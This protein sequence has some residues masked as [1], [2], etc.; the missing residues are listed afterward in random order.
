[1]EC[2]IVRILV[3]TEKKQLKRS[4]TQSQ[5]ILCKFLCSIQKL[6]EFARFS[7]V[8]Y[9]TNLLHIRGE[10]KRMKMT[11][12][13]KFDIAKLKSQYLSLYMHIIFYKR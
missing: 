13:I 4:H 12:I 11:N 5:T 1:M 6:F 2:N 8:L 10:M 9:Y 7:S 3:G